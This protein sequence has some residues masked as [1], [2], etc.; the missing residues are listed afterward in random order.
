MCGGTITRT[1][2]SRIAGLYDD[3]AV[4]PFTTASASTIVASIVS[5][6]STEIGRSSQSRSEEHTSELQSLMRNSYAVFCL[7]KKIQLCHNY[8]KVPYNKTQYVQ[9]TNTN[10]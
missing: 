1:P 3:E 7:H 2:L 10:K 6:S 5:G 8:K 4:W 9:I